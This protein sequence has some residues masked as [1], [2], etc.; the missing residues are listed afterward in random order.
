M[1]GASDQRSFSHSCSKVSAKMMHDAHLDFID[2]A[3]A[4]L[5][6]SILGGKCLMNQDQFIVSAAD[7]QG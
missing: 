1:L 5:V 7:D 3:T 2:I 4:I 6:A